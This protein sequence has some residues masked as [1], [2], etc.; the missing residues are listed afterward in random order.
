MNKKKTLLHF[1]RP[2][3]M[4]AI[5]PCVAVILILLRLTGAF[6]LLEWAA[7]DWFF[8][9]RPLELP[10]DRIVIV[11]IT[12]SDIQTAGQ[13]PIPDRTIA[14]LLDR[15]KQQQP[16]AIGFDIYRDLSVGEG[17]QELIEIFKNTPNLIGV[18]LVGSDENGIEVNPPP[19]LHDR[20]RVAASNLI[21]DNDG[22]V[23]RGL[24]FA[25]TQNGDIL[26][27]IALNLALIYLEDRGIEPENATDN[28]EYLQLNQAVFERWR[29]ND[30]S[31]IKSDDRG[32]QIFLNYRK[33][34]KPFLK[35]S[36]TDVLTNQVPDNF[37]RDR[38]VLIGSTALSIQDYF[39]TPYDSTLLGLPSRTSGVEIHANITSQILSAALDDRPL[40]KSWTEE[41]E[42]LWI[43]FWAAIGF[44]LASW[45]NYLPGKKFYYSIFQTTVTLFLSV[46]FLV[47][48]SFFIF[49]Q[50]WWIPLVPALSSSIVSAIAAIG[51]I[52]TV[53][54]KDREII[55]N[56]FERNVTDKVAENI[57]ENR[58]QILEDGQIHGQEITATVLFTDLKNFSSI[59][60]GMEPRELMS[61]LNDYMKV[62][63]QVVLEYNG[64]IDKFIGDSIM[65][66]FGIPIPSKTAE[67]IARDARQ[68]VR[69]ALAMEKALQSL[70]EQWESQGKP[71]VLMR[72]GITTGTVVV[73]SLGSDRRQDYTVIG[74]TVNIASRLESF[75]KSIEGGICRILIS[76]H[77]QKLL[78]DRF[79]TQFIGKVFLKGRK[80]PM[81]VYRVLREFHSRHKN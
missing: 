15:L 11:A 52:A 35:V 62:M 60:E 28:P 51:Y 69:C 26:P 33:P 53:E 25:E 17:H 3:E 45:Q 2:W 18:Q 65:A 75:D 77:T 43:F 44:S 38:I 61:W 21:L 5:A 27:S 57:W 79:Q 37:A 63:A 39:I 80:E 16:K 13:W 14:Q 8:R 76:E 19:L 49:L 24:L 81:Q 64:I 23:R 54:S 20:D 55:M 1:G 66:V 12:E 9:L 78:S 73:G 42:N 40:I 30:G 41:S 47:G 6:Q 72:V 34:K 59:A 70:N 29:S 48:I 31:Y 71:S 56:L 67:G 46:T 68:A 50:G 7:I 74:D 58:Y 10:D 22:K 4:L 36:M 32:Y